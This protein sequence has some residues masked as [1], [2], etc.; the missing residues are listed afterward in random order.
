MNFSDIVNLSNPQPFFNTFALTCCLI[1]MLT[2]VKAKAFFMGG[3]V[4]HAI[5]LLIVLFVSVGFAS[6]YSFSY[7]IRLIEGF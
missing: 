5:F 3:K 2:G 4:A 7:L 6:H 1:S